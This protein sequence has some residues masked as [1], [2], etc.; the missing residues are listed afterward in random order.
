MSKLR[1]FTLIELLVVIAIIALLMAILM[2]ALGRVRNQA[3]ATACQANLH[4]W[5][6]V[7]S[8]YANDHDG[9]FMKGMGGKNDAWMGA[10]RSY[11]TEAKI[12]LCPTA[13][14]FRSEGAT[15]TFSSWGIWDDDA[16][17]TAGDYGS[18][19]MNEW[20]DN[21]PPGTSSWTAHPEWNWRGIDVRGSG[22]IPL[23]L[24][25]YWDGGYPVDSESPPAFEGVVSNC[26]DRFC[27][28]RHNGF[29]NGLFLDFSVRK[30]G[31]KDL[32]KLRWHRE[33]NINGPWTKA[34]LVE[35][36]DWPEWM[37]SFKD[38]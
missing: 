32:W 29:T 5:G 14:K 31:L 17:H 35:S 34:G 37:R 23:F 28:N 6:L 9:Y 18:Y 33:F 20:C 36:G 15:G 10:L 8:A 21:P 13:T 4:Q 11:Y 24:D 1:G 7:W 25:C 38:Y 22:H 12:R 19:G 16:W 2:P 26:M 30:I 3:K 27:I